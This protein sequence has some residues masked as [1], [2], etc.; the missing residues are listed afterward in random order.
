MVRVERGVSMAPLA[1]V[2]LVAILLALNAWA[3]YLILRDPVAFSAE[4]LG[5]LLLAWFLPLA[6]ALLVIH[7]MRDELDSPTGRYREE[8]DPGDAIEALQDGLTAQNDSSC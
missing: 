6:G 8:A 2:C 5:R 4:K 3:T 1:V 7:L